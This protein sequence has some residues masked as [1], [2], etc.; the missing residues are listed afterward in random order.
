MNLKPGISVVIC[1]RARPQRL[2]TVLQSVLAQNRLPDEI[3]T[4]DAS[5]DDKTHLE[6]EAIAREHAD[7]VQFVYESARGRLAGLTRQRNR[8]AARASYDALSF[9]DDDVTLAPDCLAEMEKAFRHPSGNGHVVGVGAFIEN[10]WHF[11]TPRWR[12]RRRV[13]AIDS[14][15]PGRYARSGVSIPWSFLLPNNQQIDGDWLPGCA[16]M[17]PTQLVRELKFFELFEGYCMGEDL[18]FSLRAKEYGRLIIAGRARVNHYHEPS[19]RPNY[20][21]LGFM[22]IWNAYLIHKRCLRERTASDILWFLWA[23]FLDSA[24]GL[25][26]TLIPGTSHQPLARSIGRLRAWLFMARDLLFPSSFRVT[27]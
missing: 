20:R 7:G 4:V 15:H 24:I 26:S 27:A 19:G 13:R 17:W 6:F 23:H 8:G 16:M 5:D 11:P 22:E 18:E 10:Q 3:I 21:L 2:R 14:L 25:A 1:T 9:F 12:F